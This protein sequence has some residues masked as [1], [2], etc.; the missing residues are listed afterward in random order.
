VNDGKPAATIGRE[1]AREAEEILRRLA[2]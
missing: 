2:R 1:A